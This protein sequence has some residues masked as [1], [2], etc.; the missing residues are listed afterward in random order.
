MELAS[1]AALKSREAQS[2]NNNPEITPSL[3]SYDPSVTQETLTVSSKHTNRSERTKTEEHLPSMQNVMAAHP[4]ISPH[5]YFQAHQDVSPKNVSASLEQPVHQQP[6]DHELKTQSETIDHIQPGNDATLKVLQESLDQKLEELKSSNKKPSIS[7]IVREL[8]AEHGD[9]I[10]E[11]VI[12]NFID[13]FKEWPRKKFA[14]KIPGKILETDTPSD[15]QLILFANATYVKQRIE[16]NDRSN[17]MCNT[18]IKESLR[19]LEKEDPYLTKIIEVLLEPLL[20]TVPEANKAEFKGWVIKQ[21]LERKLANNAIPQG[22]VLWVLVDNL[23]SISKKLDLTDISLVKHNM[24]CNIKIAEARGRLP[25]DFKTDPQLDALYLAPTSPINASYAKLRESKDV[26]IFPLLNALILKFNL[27]GAELDNVKAYLHSDS[28]KEGSVALS[29]TKSM[30]GLIEDGSL[31]EGEKKQLLAL[32]FPK[33]TFATNKHKFVTNPDLINKME[34]NLK[35]FS[36]MLKNHDADTVRQVISGALASSD[37]SHYF[38]DKLAHWLGAPINIHDQKAKDNLELI[39]NFLEYTISIDLVE[40]ITPELKLIMQEALMQMIT[41]VQNPA[42]FFADRYADADRKGTHLNLCK[43]ALG[44]K[45]QTFTTTLEKPTSVPGKKVAILTGD[46]AKHLKL[47]FHA[48]EDVGSCQSYTGDFHY[49]NAL[50]GYALDGKNQLLAVYNEKT[51]V[52]IGRSILRILL[53]ENSKPVLYIESLYGNVSLNDQ[54]TLLSLAK[55]RADELGVPLLISGKFHK[56]LSS[57]VNAHS[58]EQEL[59]SV[60]G[61]KREYI[62][63]GTVEN[64][65]IAENGQYALKGGSSG[66]LVIDSVK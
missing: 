40:Q 45:W 30:I 28:L 46:E 19:C 56:Q 58:N 61:W 55:E 12:V 22:I 63:S 54:K 41:S 20:K 9:N 44:D 37:L 35:F 23:I 49:N 62:D 36:I 42:Q 4:G 7:N 53:D 16:V 29:V 60:S 65:N 11:E 59:T 33:P 14:F 38:I 13:N 24:Q 34:I 57:L 6:V 52:I 10:T 2:R 47:F 25:T 50:L 66:R 43:E 32:I 26:N 18:L 64:T 27:E 17:F 48:G 39:S 21:I 8:R 15:I 51:N 3:H 1:G 5:N 31:N